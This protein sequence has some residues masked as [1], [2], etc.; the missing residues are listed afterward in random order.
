MKIPSDFTI[1][2]WLAYKGDFFGHHRIIIVYETTEY[3]LY[4]IVTSQIEKAEKRNLFDKASLVKI[5]PTDWDQ[6]K[7]PSCIECSKRNLKQ[8]SKSEMMKKH[9]S[10]ACRNIGEIPDILKERILEAMRASV[11]YSERE[12]SIYTF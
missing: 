10:W 2:R 9:D 4:F 8:I 6:I 5:F 12:K 7:C 11:T 1:S 3:V